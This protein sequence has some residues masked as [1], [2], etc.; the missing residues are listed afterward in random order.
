LAN[1]ILIVKRTALLLCSAIAL[2]SAGPALAQFAPHPDPPAVAQAREKVFA[3][4]Y[5]QRAPAQE[6]LLAEVAKAFGKDSEAY[7]A[8]LVVYADALGTGGRTPEALKAIEQAIALRIKLTGDENSLAVGYT[9]R[10]YS[11]VLLG[12]GFRDRA[13]DELGKFITALTE[14]VY[15]CG[16]VRE[17][18]PVQGLP[19]TRLI[20]GCSEDDEAL[21]GYLVRYVQLLRDLG[22]SKEGM[23]RFRAVKERFEPRWAGCD[24][25]VWKTSCDRAA[26]NRRKFMFNYAA[27]LAGE[28]QAGEAYAIVRDNVA[29]RLEEWEKAGKDNARPSNDAS[30]DGSDD[31]WLF[32]DFQ[33]LVSATV[34]AHPEQVLDLKFRWLPVFAARPAYARGKLEEAAYW[35]K[36]LRERLDE[37]LVKLVD[38]ALAAG[39]RDQLQG[40][41]AAMGQ[42]ALLAG[43]DDAADLS[44]QIAA[45]DQ[46]FGDTDYS[47]YA[48]RAAILAQKAELIKASKGEASTEYLDALL[49]VARQLRDSWHPEDKP[50][51]EAAFRTALAA[52]RKGKG[53]SDSATL[54]ALSSLQRF[55]MD[56]GR[57]DDAIAIMS[58]I[59]ADPGNGKM[60]EYTDPARSRFLSSGLNSLAFGSDYILNGLKVDLARLL[61]GKGDAK[62]ALPAARH[63]AI[64]RRAWLASFG[65]SRADEDAYG[66]AVDESSFIV[67]LSKFGEYP[68]LQADALW[69]AGERGDAATAEAF[70]ALQDAQMGTTSR[71]VA[72]AAAE[73]LASGAGAADLLEERG[74]IDA[75]ARAASDAFMAASQLRTPEGDKLSTEKFDAMNRLQVLR[76]DID[77]RI[78][79][80][81]PGYFELVRPKALS[82]ENARALLAPDEA[83]LLIVPSARGT[84][85]A[86]VTHDGVTWRRSDLKEAELNRHVRRLLWDAGAK[87]SVS[88]EEK[89]QWESE[90][91]GLF[92]FDRTT[93]HTLYRE[94]VAPFE[95]ELAGRKF[96]FVAANG[97]LSSLP[98]SL[99]VTAAPT[100]SD[101]VPANLRQTPWLGDRFVLL[102]LPSLQSLQLLRTA[103][104]GQ[105]AAPA[106][107][108]GAMSLLGFGDP[109]LEGDPIQ[110]GVR[111]RTRDA[112]AAEP[113]LPAMFAPPVAGEVRLADPAVL[114]KMGRLPGTQRELAAM[115]KVVGPGNS[116][117][118]TGAKATERNFKAADLQHASILFLATHGL[119]AGEIENIGEPGLVLTP[120]GRASRED[121]GLLTASE[122]VALRL[123]AD[124]V[125][126]SACNTAAGDGSEGAPGLSGLARAFFFAGAKSLLASHW[127][128]RDDVAEVLTVRIFELQRENPGWSRA[129]ALQAAIK[130]IRDD[131]RA[132]EDVASW[133]H[134]SAWA[135]FTLIGDVD[136]R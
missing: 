132:D 50:A 20:L 108:P 13:A 101:G 19:P 52:A 34:T 115:Q 105:P 93:A 61:L 111:G 41:L 42:D 26:E 51:T 109:V 79:A 94:L 40:V 23:D 98:L 135:P 112:G 17:L 126:L 9:R 136:R 39:R 56:A 48:D 120:P 64:G 55:L 77:T 131:P 87:V 134:P 1:G 70:I 133:S 37:S 11:D 59:L 67:S 118:F 24:G 3:A 53:D 27:A 29:P 21:A 100:D 86:L 102:Q 31:Y 66:E 75:D 62:N 95:G 45:L 76:E 89:A 28:G 43:K 16:T 125:I 10:S 88:A 123:N 32:S 74:K 36:A 58:E 121:D 73:R 65:Y 46:Q 85:L 128:V 33:T 72:R 18:P 122:V 81:A 117:V 110:R 47:R 114:R 97:A 8:E 60:A 57:Q 30:D 2:F 82:V 49:D 104:P 5:D 116:R 107:S 14:E 130:Q 25:P 124:W 113:E 22:R 6:R 90:G 71:A 129:E 103:A 54:L 38:D 44:T 80:A 7:A 69:E 92:P 119:L 83:M 91:T 84:H 96:L 12:N 15:R 68:V 35:D 99:L 127:P 78:R 106:S 63:A 4:P